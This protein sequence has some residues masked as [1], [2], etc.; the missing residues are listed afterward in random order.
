MRARPPALALAL[1][2]LVAS[3]LF[4]RPSVAQTPDPSPATSGLG[5][6][7]TAHP[8]PGPPP[9]IAAAGDIACDP[10][11]PN[12]NDGRG[13][14]GLCKQKATSR[15][16]RSLA[17]D[18]VLVLGDAQY[19]D[20]KLTKFQ[21]SY[22]ASWGT[23]LDI[24][25]PAPGN[26]E[27]VT[28]AVGY[29]RYF[30]SRATPQGTTYYSFDL[31]SWHLISLDSDC[32]AVPCG[33]GSAQYEWL[34]ADLEAAAASGDGICELAYFHHPRFSS[35]PHGNNH[36]VSPFWRLLYRYGVDVVLNGHD[37]LYE[38]FAPLTPLGTVDRAGGVR[39]FVV[40][41][42]G[43]VHYPVRDVQP[44]S[45]RRGTGVFG[46]LSMTLHPDAYDWRFVPV[47]GGSFSEAGTASCH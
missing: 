7:E 46:V 32:W 29:R 13:R 39:E 28:D 22:A 18:A 26:H 44:H 6:D 21:K 37:H 43:A 34:K 41:T 31:Q 11:D 8:D 20:G 10:A 38:R 4:A 42:G 2:A 47:K 19:D 23:Y 35:G 17:P 9:T 5:T 36:F 45:Q 12:F 33:P 24:T 27:Y 1:A 30:G 3:F 14:N 15:L 16:F 25:H 40:G